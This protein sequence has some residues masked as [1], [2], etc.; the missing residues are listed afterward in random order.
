MPR[1]RWGRT[2]TCHI[3]NRPMATFQEQ[4]SARGSS[5]DAESIIGECASQCDLR[6]LRHRTPQTAWVVSRSFEAQLRGLRLRDCITERTAS[7]RDKRVAPGN[8]RAQALQPGSMIEAA[9]GTEIRAIVAMDVGLRSR[10]IAAPLTANR[11]CP[12]DLTRV[13]RFRSADRQPAVSPHKTDRLPSGFFRLP[14]AEAYPGTTA[15]FIDEFNASAL[16][17]AANGQVIRYSH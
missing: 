2:S 13:G 12:S 7:R 4:R 9:S 8:V 14:F 3:E 16:E 17:C 10:I 11:R 1:K 6:V 15:V 5:A